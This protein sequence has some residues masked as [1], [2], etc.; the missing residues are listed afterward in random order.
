MAPESVEATI[1]NGEDQHEDKKS[2]PGSNTTAANMQQGGRH[3]HRPLLDTRISYMLKTFPAH[4]MQ[5]HGFF[6]C[7]LFPLIISS[8]RSSILK[9]LFQ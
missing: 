2:I 5:N 6:P 1:T 3:H 9:T 8:H 4:G 7:A